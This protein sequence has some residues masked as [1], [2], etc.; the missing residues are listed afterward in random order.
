MT[1][2][3]KTS[4]TNFSRKLQ[5]GEMTNLEQKNILCVSFVL[6]EGEKRL[7]ENFLRE[8]CECTSLCGMNA[9]KGKNRQKSKKMRKNI[10]FAPRKNVIFI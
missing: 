10:N 1:G 3:S 9:P 6:S 8:E 7:S 5:K 4:I 2:G